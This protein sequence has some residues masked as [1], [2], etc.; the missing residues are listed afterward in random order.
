[1]VSSTWVHSRLWCGSL[2]SYRLPDQE[3]AEVEKQLSKLYFDSY[4]FADLRMQIR[5]KLRELP[6]ASQLQS[7]PGGYW[8]VLELLDEY[9]PVILSIQ[10]YHSTRSSNSTPLP[11]LLTVFPPLFFGYGDFSLLSDRLVGKQNCAQ[12][13]LP[14]ELVLTLCTMAQLYA[15]HAESQILQR[16]KPLTIA[17]WPR[18]Q[19]A[20][21][22]WQS[23][24]GF[25][26]WAASYADKMK[27]E[28][29]STDALTIQLW[30][31]F[32]AMTSYFAILSRLCSTHGLSTHIS[33]L[34]LT[35]M[36]PERLARIGSLCAR[37]ALTLVHEANSLQPELVESS[38]SQQLQWCLS[39]YE[40]RWMTIYY[41]YELTVYRLDANPEIAIYFCDRLL[42]LRIPQF[43]SPA[44]PQDSNFAAFAHDIQLK[45]HR[46]L[47]DALD[48]KKSLRELCRGRFGTTRGSR[49]L[50]KCLRGEFLT[51]RDIGPVFS[52]QQRQVDTGLGEEE[53][54]YV[55]PFLV[56]VITKNVEEALLPVKTEDPALSNECEIVV[57]MKSE[58][59]D[60]K[61]LTECHTVKAVDESGQ[62]EKR[63]SNATP[64]WV[65]MNYGGKLLHFEKAV[66]PLPSVNSVQ[67]K[68]SVVRTK[69]RPSSSPIYLSRKPSPQDHSKL[70]RASC[71][72]CERRFV[73]SSLPGVVIMKR[74]YE[75]R[76]QWG[77]IQDSKKFN[78]PS[79]LYGTASVCLLCNEILTHEQEAAKGV[80]LQTP[81]VDD[82]GRMILN[83]IVNRWHQSPC[84]RDADSLE[85]IAGNKRVR[86]S[87]TVFNMKA[88]NA[89]DPN[90][91]RSAHTKEELQPWWEI[92]L[93]NYVQVHSVKVY[94]RD[95]VS[96]LY[97]APGRH[98]TGMYPLHLSVSMKTGVGR[99]CNDI[100]ASCVTSLYVSDF[101]GPL[102]N[103]EA[104][105]KSRGRFVRIQCQGRAILHV[106]RVHV[107]V[108][109][110]PVEPAVR[111]Q[112]FRQKLQRAAFCA[113]VMATAAPSSGSNR[114]AVTTEPT[115]K[116]RASTQA[117]GTQRGSQLTLESESSALFFD[118]E[119][120]E[121]KRISRL[122]TRFKSLLDARAK[123]VA[124]EEDSEETT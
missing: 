113:S 58:E 51:V 112:H 123:Y 101:M 10:R 50:D 111:R 43:T 124:P 65:T 90:A 49:V 98:T 23:A 75:L 87:S 84:V 21:L 70:T 41:Q 67:D 103:W 38:F 97:A 34:A 71:A 55:S 85:D 1:M 33:G 48:V 11:S 72:L 102:I 105:P 46:Q 37:R 121:R 86:Q 13:C 80:E 32:N 114:V 100:V 4:K 45:H 109:K 35:E 108:A 2:P 28:L 119:R 95:E 110:A 44:S 79:V 106:E 30:R 16:G 31:F 22:S 92:D 5:L 117:V 53:S 94:L 88:Q 40:T 73:R 25:Y 116:R 78:A 66:D 26:R 61:G 68:C 56:G 52:D 63:P 42:K 3:E 19:H 14:V 99:D 69:P 115:P 60:S 74:V 96:H 17:Y 120:A 77:V 118:P 24:E 93:A 18:M 104:P 39:A 7:D 89:L 8:E 20:E 122:Y 91:N 29:D 107:Y 9:L 64:G 59:S 47:T 6:V 76:R 15:L 62:V 54:N 81:A 27:E 36:R 57:T 12:F 83:S 82:V